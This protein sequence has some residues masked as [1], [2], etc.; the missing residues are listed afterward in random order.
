MNEGNCQAA[1]DFKSKENKA[2]EGLLTKT[3]KA[4]LQRHF[5]KKL[6][7]WAASG[8]EDLVFSEKALLTQTQSFL[9]PHITEISYRNH[10]ST[11][12]GQKPDS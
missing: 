5:S 7:F 10:K 2:L 1:Q 12:D 4:R 8:K 3:V 9:M 11:Q 6:S